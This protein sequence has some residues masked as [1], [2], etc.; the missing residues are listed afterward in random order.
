[1]NFLRVRVASALSIII[2]IVF[3]QGCEIPEGVTYF[4]KDAAFPY[5]CDKAKTCC[6]KPYY[7]G[8]HGCYDT[9]AGCTS[10]GATCEECKIEAKNP[11]LKTLGKYDGT[12]NWSL[13][14]VNGINSACFSCAIIKDNQLT[15]DGTFLGPIEVSG[16]KLTFYGACPN[17]STSKGTF[18]GT[19]GGATKKAWQGTWSCADGSTG[20]SASVWKLFQN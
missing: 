16:T 12:Y 4:C 11:I 13:S 3:V 2:V 1:M 14:N 8:N 7:N 20:G 5:W 10:S 9:M 6:G 17:G 18:T 19:Q 15:I